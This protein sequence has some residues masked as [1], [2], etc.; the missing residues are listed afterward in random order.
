MRRNR[1]LFEKSDLPDNHVDESTFMSNLVKNKNVRRK[2]T[3]NFVP[4]KAVE[5]GKIIKIMK[6]KLYSKSKIKYKY[7][8]IDKKIYCSNRIKKMFK[9]NITNIEKILI[10]NL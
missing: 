6:D 2:E 5:I 4:S 7:T 10:R 8:K 9:F 3:V 1:K